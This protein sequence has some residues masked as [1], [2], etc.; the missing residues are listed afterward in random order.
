[1][2]I[3]SLLQVVH[4]VSLH[5]WKTNKVV[6]VKWRIHWQQLHR[7]SLFLVLDIVGIR[8]IGITE[9]R[10]Q[11]TQSHRIDSLAL[12]CLPGDAAP[13]RGRPG[14]PSLRQPEGHAGQGGRDLDLFPVQSAN[15]PRGG[16]P[17]G[18]AEDQMLRYALIAPPAARK[19][20]LSPLIF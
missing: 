13:D 7:E 12:L 17:A 10:A 20:A 8:R 6:F 3:L 14:P 5:I 18:G 11:M 15:R 19:P 4:L 9:R 16:G 1:M 2:D